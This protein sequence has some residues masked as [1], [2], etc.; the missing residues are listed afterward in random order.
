LRGLPAHT[1]KAPQ[2]HYTGSECHSPNISWRLL[3]G[4]KPFWQFGTDYGELAEDQF[5]FER[6]A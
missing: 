3:N 2:F 5:V 6:L 4:I 1:A